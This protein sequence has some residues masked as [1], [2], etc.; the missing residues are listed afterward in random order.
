M[1]GSAATFVALQYFF[2]AKE[3]Q[4]APVVVLNGSTPKTIRLTDFQSDRQFCKFS[5]LEVVIQEVRSYGDSRDPIKKDKPV[6]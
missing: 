1:T 5:K 6:F 2:I 3:L 4:I